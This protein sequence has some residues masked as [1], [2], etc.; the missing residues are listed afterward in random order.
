MSI[1]IANEQQESATGIVIEGHNLVPT[2][3]AGIGKVFLLNVIAK[4]LQVF[5]RPFP[6]LCTTGIA[7]MQ[8][9]EFGAT[10]GHR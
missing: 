4:E 9:R 7:C 3:Q 10:T 2:G 8:F 6:L 5:E 1:N